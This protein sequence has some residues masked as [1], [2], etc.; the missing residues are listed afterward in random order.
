MEYFGKNTDEQALLD[1]LDARKETKG[2]TTQE[3]ISKLNKV[4]DYY[5]E[6]VMYD[7]DFHMHVCLHSNNEKA[8]GYLNNKVIALVEV[9]LLF[10]N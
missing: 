6:S 9:K 1:F 3:L 10:R 8:Q 5:R 2:W 7:F 4:L